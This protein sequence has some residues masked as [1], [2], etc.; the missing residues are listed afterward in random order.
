MSIFLYTVNVAGAQQPSSKK[1][2]HM[3]SHSPSKSKTP[4]AKSEDDGTTG[5]MGKDTVKL[6][7]KGMER[8]LNANTGVP[9]PP[10]SGSGTKK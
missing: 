10:N 5:V 7:G 4:P 2:S 3:K 6:N 9:L 8:N 1:H